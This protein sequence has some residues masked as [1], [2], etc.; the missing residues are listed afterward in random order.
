MEQKIR[1]V[2]AEP[3]MQQNA[4]QTIS[5]RIADLEARKEVKD[6]ALAEVQVEEK[7]LID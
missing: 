1:D 7:A 3:F 5:T 6:K 2:M 4:G